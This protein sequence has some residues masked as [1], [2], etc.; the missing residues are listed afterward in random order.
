[1]ETTQSMPEG[2]NRHKEQN[3]SVVYN[4]TVKLLTLGNLPFW[5]PL[6]TPLAAVPVARWRSALWDLSSWLKTLRRSGALVWY[7]RG[8]PRTVQAASLGQVWTTNSKPLIR[9]NLKCIHSH[10]FGKS[11]FLFWN[12]KE[13]KTLC[14]YRLSP[15]GWH[16]LPDVFKT[17]YKADCCCG[18]WMWN[19]L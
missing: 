7:L 1:M 6:G 2:E 9:I 3:V 12:W 11:N 18:L 13:R 15:V 16:D 10:W 5:I 14:L 17:H 19:L 4:S 8:R